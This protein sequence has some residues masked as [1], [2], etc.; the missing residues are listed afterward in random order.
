MKQTTTWK[1]DTC[2][3]VLEYEWDDQLPQ[4]ERI[5]SFKTLIGQCPDHLGL[6][7]SKVYEHVLAE[8]QTKNKVLGEALKN[9]T[10]LKTIKVNEDG[11]ETEI[12]DPKISYEWSFTGKDD[13]RV[14]VV[15]FKGVNLT[16]NEKALISSISFDK[17]VEIS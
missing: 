6:T 8:N 1:P 10:K 5:H 9:I 14:L 3:C 17:T 13:Q 4:N 16:T 12:L 2:G 15:N 11:T 7:D